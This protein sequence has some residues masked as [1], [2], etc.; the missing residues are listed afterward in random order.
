[1]GVAKLNVAAFSNA[2]LFDSIMLSMCSKSQATGSVVDKDGVIRLGDDILSKGQVHS[3]LPFAEQE[4]GKLEIMASAYGVLGERSPLHENHATLMEAIILTREVRFP[5]LETG[6]PG[7]CL[8]AMYKVQVNH[9][10]RR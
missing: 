6:L 8:Y 3:L 5:L 7:I 2:I 4:G 9:S 10:L 1:M